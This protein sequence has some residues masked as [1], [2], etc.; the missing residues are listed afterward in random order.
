MDFSI[1]P[2]IKTPKDLWDYFQ[3]VGPTDKDG[4][5]N[6]VFVSTAIRKAWLLSHKVIMISCTAYYP[7]FTNKEGGVWECHLEISER[8]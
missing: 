6:Y 1:E 2:I 8:R 5:A 4:K 7:Y 3:S